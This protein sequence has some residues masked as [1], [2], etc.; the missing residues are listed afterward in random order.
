MRTRPA[1][2]GAALLAAA[3]VITSCGSDAD[4]DAAGSGGGGEASGASSDAFPVTVPTAFGDVTVEEEPVRVVALGWGDAETA[5]ALGVQPVGA[6][7]WLAFGGEG[8]GP[9]AEGLYDE[10][11]E[12][13]ETLE[14]SYEAIAALEPD[15]I[16]DTK[17]PATQERYDTLSAIAPTIA[18]PEGADPYLT[19]SAQQLEMI[20]QAL[21]KADEAADLQAEIDQAFADAAAAN[22]AFEGTEVA[23]AAYSSEGFGAYVRG[24]AR[25]DFMEQLGFTLKPAIQELATDSFFVSVSEEQLPLLDAGLTVAFP[26]FVQASEITSN[27]LWQAIPSVQAG[28]GIVLEDET[29]VSAFSIGTPQGIQYALENAVPLFADALG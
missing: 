4:D 5:L 26:I 27:P 16:L 19:G 28:H 22:P 6:S 25:V 17:S 15:L 7:D 24:D 10:A 20:G 8:V 29:L 1:L 12:I 13:I 3:L 9:W 21:G 18:Q 11:P 2:R 23:V 14:P